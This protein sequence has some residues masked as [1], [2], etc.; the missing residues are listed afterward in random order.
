MTI[1][2]RGNQIGG[3]VEVRLQEGVRITADNNNIFPATPVAVGL[4][5]YTAGINGTQ[6]GDQFTID[7]NKDGTSHN[8]NALAMAGLET[9]G[10]VGAEVST[11]NEAYSQ[12]VEV[13][14]SVASQAEIDSQSS[15]S[16]LTQS[17]N[18]WQE[19][20]GVNLDEEAGKLIQFQAAYNAS[21]QVVSIARQFLTHC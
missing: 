11:Y 4:Y 2:G 10:T 9:S 6:K 20:S 18:R 7:Y 16:L 5:H 8:R 1:P 13:V 19:M 15:K 3:Q 21:A 12:L 17:E 14:G